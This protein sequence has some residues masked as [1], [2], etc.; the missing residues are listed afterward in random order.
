MK[1]NCQGWL[2]PFYSYEVCNL[3]H[4]FVFQIEICPQKAAARAYFRIEK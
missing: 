3:L 2:C 4:K 1:R